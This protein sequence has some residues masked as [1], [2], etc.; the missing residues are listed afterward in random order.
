M[1]ITPSDDTRWVDSLR[2]LGRRGIRG[3]AVVLDTASFGRPSNTEA[4]LANLVQ[5]GIRVYR[6]CAGD[7]L[8]EALSRPYNHAS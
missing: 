1:V 6:V 7:S 8:T 5:N 4:M 2:D 3:A